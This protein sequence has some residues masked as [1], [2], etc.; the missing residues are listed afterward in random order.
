MKLISVSTVSRSRSHQDPIAGNRYG[1]HAQY[2]RA[3]G[4]HLG[5]KVECWAIDVAQRATH[6]E[7]VDGVR[8]RVFPADRFVAPNREWSRSLLQALHA[9]VADGAIVHI[10]DVHSW[11]FYAVARALPGAKLVG[12]FHGAS[13]P[14][15]HRV[16]PW[17]K[18]PFVPLFIAEQ[19]AENR[20]LRK[21]RHCFVVNNASAAYF[22]QRG[23]ATSFCPMAPNMDQLPLHQRN[24]AR[25]QL[26]LHV[27]DRILLSASGFS[28]PK[29]LAL[30]VEAF[31]HIADH[32][33][34]AKLIIVGHTFDRS[35]RATIERR[36]ARHRLAKRTTII[37]FIPRETLALYYAAANVV[38]ITSTAD[39]G[40]PMAA[41]EACAVGA[42][43]VATP[44]GFIPDFAPRSSGLI[45]LASFDP[46]RFAD[47]VLRVMAGLQPP[48]RPLWTWD[49]VAR[50]VRPVYERLAA[51]P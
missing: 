40:G 42:P 6:D 45:T 20:A 4:Q 18:L 29:N 44:I 41:L 2:G 30:L 51:Q 28:K 17:R 32:Q 15:L 37:D 33:P 36:L 19:L 11:P 48:P 24:D 23:V 35:Y 9:E 26:S 21:L 7:T 22:K 47:D 27:H 39:E 50:V 5:L 34:S 31:R 14:P 25:Q 46:M 49:D 12:H 10:H 3:V 38:L 43:V 16:P 8:Y 1:W 13:R